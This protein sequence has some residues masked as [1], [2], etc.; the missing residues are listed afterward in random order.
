MN[1][2]TKLTFVRRE[3]VVNDPP[4]TPVI[5]Q[6]KNKNDTNPGILAA[7]VTVLVVLLIV[8][9]VLLFFAIRRLRKI[10]KAEQTAKSASHLQLPEHV[11]A[12]SDPVKFTIPTAPQLPHEMPRGYIHHI[13]AST[14]Y[15]PRRKISANGKNGQQRAP[16]LSVIG[17]SKSDKPSATSSENAALLFRSK[18]VPCKLG[19]QKGP[20][21][22]TIGVINPELYAPQGDMEAYQPSKYGF[23]KLS[24]SLAYDKELGVLTL[25][26][27][28]AA[29][30]PGSTC[31]QKANDTFVKI[32][33][34]P[35]E[36]NRR[37]ATSKVFRRSVNPRYNQ[38][39]VF[40]L[41][42]SD[43]PDTLIRF[44]VFQYDRYS[45]PQVIGKAEYELGSHDF[46]V[47][48]T[49]N[50]IWRDLVEHPWEAEVRLL[51]GTAAS[52]QKNNLFCTLSQNYQHFFRKK[53]IC[54]L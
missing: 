40:R 26:L 27:I 32:Y 31:Q 12:F 13:R 10:I 34:V 52:N 11:K 24:F 25:N 42:A 41:I 16:R 6:T 15:E 2:S 44:V 53:Y 3:I 43:L 23:G 38:T 20:I 33:L 49:H 9:A 51:R 54:V 47:L 18:S 39:F 36:D 45:H 7:G 8:T 1:N 30:L 21:R 46:D 35:D 14:P 22:S 5:L 19:R 50:T 4:V 28:Q 48:G 17:R 37:M 29:Q